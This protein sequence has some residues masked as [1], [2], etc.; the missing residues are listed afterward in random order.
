M[1]RMKLL[2]LTIILAR[3]SVSGDIYTERDGASQDTKDHNHD[4]PGRLKSA[5]LGHC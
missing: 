2:S 3:L 1:S 4:T 5:Q